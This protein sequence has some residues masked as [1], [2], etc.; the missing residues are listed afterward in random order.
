MDA[1][2]YLKDVSKKAQQVWMI[3]FDKK[4]KF[5]IEKQISLYNSDYLEEISEMYQS[6][7]IMIITM[8]MLKNL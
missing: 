3:E 7:R 5:F 1:L 8:N 4:V 2:E 6:T